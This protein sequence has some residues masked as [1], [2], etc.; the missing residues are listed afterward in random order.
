[1]HTRSRR[2]GAPFYLD[3]AARLSWADVRVPENMHRALRQLSVEE[4]GEGQGSESGRHTCF[5]AAIVAIAFRVRAARL[6]SG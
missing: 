5:R 3:H 1:M 2:R 6:V 4:S